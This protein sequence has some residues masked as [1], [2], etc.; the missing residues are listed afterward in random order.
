[1]IT[2]KWELLNEN[3]FRAKGMVV[4]VKTAL[5]AVKE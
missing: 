5:I 4:T 1:M 2:W 3:E